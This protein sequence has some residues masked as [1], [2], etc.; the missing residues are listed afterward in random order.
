MVRGLDFRQR[1]FLP[2]GKVLKEGTH[3]VGSFSNN[4]LGRR[5]G[6][7][8]PLPYVPE[9]TYSPEMKSIGATKSQWFKQIII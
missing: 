2:K 3:E 4:G 6:G 5:R 7:Q 1:T 9:K 8:V